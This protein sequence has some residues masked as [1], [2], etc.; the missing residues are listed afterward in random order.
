MPTPLRNFRIADDLWLAVQAKAAEEGES[1]TAVV[2]A[3][4]EK[5]VSR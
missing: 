4:L 5:Y 2:V 1:V 3:A